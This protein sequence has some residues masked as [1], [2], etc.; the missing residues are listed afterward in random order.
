M[1]PYIGEIRL[2]AGNFAPRGWALCDGSLLQVQHYSALYSVLGNVYGGDGKTTFALP[3]MLGR[4]AI[5]QGNG[6]GL[7]PRQQGAAVG[8]TTETLTM[9]QIPRHTHM[10]N[11]T[12]V[13]SKETATADP[14]NA[15]W[16][17]E[18]VAA[19]LKPYAADIGVNMHPTAVSFVGGNQPHNNMQPFLALT[20][21]IAIEGVYPPKQ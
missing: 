18:S 6:P 8:Q 11:G 12:T 3:N 16:G 19:P 10:A 17:S 4:A 1:D 2:F 7:T 21:I 15:I 14:T 13:S 9:N 20:F 5:G